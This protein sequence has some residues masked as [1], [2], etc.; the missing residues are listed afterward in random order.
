MNPQHNK[1]SENTFPISVNWI[2]SG[3]IVYDIPGHEIRKP[4]PKAAPSCTISKPDEEEDKGN[5]SDDQKE[6]KQPK[7]P[8]IQQPTTESQ[9]N[10]KNSKKESTTS[11]QCKERKQVSDDMDKLECAVEGD[12]KP[13]VQKR[14]G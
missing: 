10:S 11:S 9:S 2:P 8:P 13:F 12:T 14:G 4:R 1:L 5:D 6:N 3:W 7:N